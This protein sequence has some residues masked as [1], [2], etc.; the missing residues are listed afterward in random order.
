MA[1]TSSGYAPPFSPIPLPM[2]SRTLASLRRLTAILLLAI[3][4][5]GGAGAGAAAA[6]GDDATVAGGVTDPSGAP[7]PDCA[8]ALA[9]ED[10]AEIRSRS[11]GPL[12]EYRFVG[13]PPGRYR[14]SFRRAGYE[15]IPDEALTVEGGTFVSLDAVLE[16]EGTGSGSGRVAAS[17]RITRS[18]VGSGSG[19][20]LDRTRLDEI[21]VGRSLWATLEATPGL[22]VDRVDVGGL[23]GAQQAS[24][25][26]TGTSYAQNRYI[27][28]GIDVTDDS[29]LGASSTYYSYDS[30]EDVLV[31]TGSHPADVASPGVLVQVETRSGTA[32]GWGGGA[33]FYFEN[34]ALQ[35]DNLDDRL[36]AQ[37]VS[38]SN[39]LDS[40]RDVSLELGGPLVRE[41]AFF[42]V[43]YARQAIDPFV[44][45]FF[46]PSGEPAVDSTDLDTI[47]AR[48]TI[49]FHSESKLALFFHRNDK[50][51][52]H[53]DASRS[54]PDPAT[55]L[56]QDSKTS[57]YQARYSDP[58]GESTLLDAQAGFV[59]LHFPLGESPD[60]PPDSFS[61]IELANGV[62]SG[63][64]GTSELFDRRDFQASASL[65]W[66]SDRWRSG[67][68]DLRLGWA[69]R[70]SS[71]RATDD[72][73][74]A[75]LYRDL[76]GAPLQVEI[77]AQP[78]T[79]VNRL[80]NQALYVEDGYVKGSLALE[81]GLRFDWWSASYPDQARSAGRW[82]EFF[83]SHGLPTATAGRVAARFVSLAPRLFFSYDVTGKGL[84]FL[85]G[86]Y[87]RYGHE[88]GTGLA[89]FA[90]PNGPAAALLRFDDRNG[91]R[92]VDPGEIDLDA[93]LSLSLPTAH[94]IDPGLAQPLT[95]EVTLGIERTFRRNLA[96]AATLLYRR[97]HRLI[98]DVNVGVPTSEYV[99]GL[100]LDPGRDLAVGTA[101]DGVVPIFNQSRQ[102]LGRDRL[103]LENP[104]GLDG[105]Y[106]GIR[107]EARKR[108]GGRWQAGASLTL[109][110]SKGYLPGPGLEGTEGAAYA[111]PL[112]NNPNTLT[113]AEG[114][115]FWDRPRMFRLA[116]SFAWK[117]GLSFAG[118]YR[119]QV[120]QPLYRSILVSKT[121]SGVPL[122]QGPVEILAESQGSALAPDLHLVDLRATKTFR[123]GGRGDL[124]LVL[125]LFNALNASTAT[126][127]SS[128]QGAFGAV[129][130]I[131]P[132][133][134]ARIGIRYRFG[135]TR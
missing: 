34:G 126:E 42:H 4:G 10:G 80:A 103:V 49:A 22:V 15:P 124:D 92:V 82:E 94:E 46:L 19:L 91:N 81:L 25:S 32:N 110:E 3:A 38:E 62:R 52:P 107:I 26:A 48:G 37:G 9:S 14:I 119:Y 16:V 63:G 133:R 99:E 131:L 69:T 93:P 59:D 41:R 20:D 58:L 33:A 127:M 135:A 21:P 40:F 23:G 125:D 55:T 8:V 74:G 117:W 31:S 106:R 96:V 30:F 28:N 100:A 101:D 65:H 104:E 114:R 88:I 76:F 120:G 113:H 121:N 108:G 51:R 67:S 27:L 64:P 73:T 86:G 128:R 84:T 61:R 98:D 6:A 57:V 71:A 85:R 39:R 123:F 90:N 87:A 1:D 102:S 79:A 24:F 18:R 7:V 78:L 36:R 54:R 70:M 115:T 83:S 12:G 105:R 11:T 75:I 44:I 13:L 56:H 134:V 43:S 118:T 53:R 97:D 89:S 29:A 72:L 66:L 45:G 116:S 122:N 2:M 5:A 129:L 109:G 60:L 35:S 17:V 77:Y 111:T 50:L 68:H 95:D 132:A 130:A 47:T 112:F